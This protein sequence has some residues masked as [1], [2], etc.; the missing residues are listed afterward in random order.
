MSLKEVEKELKAEE[1]ECQRCGGLVR[2]ATSADRFVILGLELEESQRKVHVLAVQH[3]N[4]TRHQKA[5]LTEQRN[6]LRAKIQNW[7]KLHSIYLPRLLQY[8][9]DIEVSANK[10][11]D[12]S[13]VNPEDI[14]LWLPS[15]VPDVNREHVCMDGL[16]TIEDRLLKTRMIQY[17]NKNIR[18]QRDST[19][20]RS[21]IDSVHQRALNFATQYRVA[22]AMKLALAGPGEWEKMYRVLENGDIWSYTDAD[23]SKLWVGR[24]GTNEDSD[25]PSGLDTGCPP[26]QDM[27][28]DAKECT[29][30]EGTD[31]TH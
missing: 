21:V 16:P 23:H 26:E 31:Q 12:D 28:L 17:K 3:K 14:T 30:R 10:S 4:P 1:E 15:A 13:V 19:R 8:L 27:T 7:E 9:S 20:S 5:S 29:R 18:G 11:A 22:R 6:I 24:K 2:H 25:Q